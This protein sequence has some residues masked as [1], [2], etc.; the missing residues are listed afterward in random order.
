[1]YYIIRNT[2]DMNTD[3]FNQWQMVILYYGGTFNNVMVFNIISQ[4]AP[5]SNFKIYFI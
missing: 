2:V 5:I 4:I 3:I 1:M